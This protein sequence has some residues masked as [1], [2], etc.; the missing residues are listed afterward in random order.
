[1]L[2]NNEITSLPRLANQLPRLRSINLSNNQLT[3][4][5]RGSLPDS[6]EDAWLDSNL[7]ET[8]SRKIFSNLSNMKRVYLMNNKI[9]V[10]E[11]GSFSG[12]PSLLEL[13]LSNNELTKIPTLT[14]SKSL[15]LLDLSNNR[16]SDLD[17]T[18]LELPNLER[19]DLQ[20]NSLLSFSGLKLPQLAQINLSSNRLTSL[21]HSI[22]QSE[23]LTS[24]DVSA[25]PLN[26]LPVDIFQKLGELKSLNVAAH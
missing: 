17:G 4:I 9:S 21:D 8:I 1:M 15:L 24:L 10:I 20:G 14:D 5:S 25:N 13:K 23:G 16:L 3:S 11:P 18:L 22:L 12:L 26:E 2:V 19:L 7:V 6:I